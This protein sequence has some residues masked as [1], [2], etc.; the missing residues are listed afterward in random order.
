VSWKKS[1]GHR[2]PKKK[3]YWKSGN[4]RFGSRAAAV[5]CGLTAA[6][7]ACAQPAQPSANDIL[8]AA[9]EAIGG[10]ARLDKIHS[11]SIWGADQRASGPSS[12]MQFQIEMPGRFLQERTTMGNGGQIA[13]T[14]TSEDGASSAEGGMPGDSGGPA[15][16]SYATECLNE[17]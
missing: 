12:V 14:V 15:L 4:V 6:A 8:A 3:R 1:T 2:K 10:A 17:D 13:R 16:S 5:C 7:L 9:K 11:L